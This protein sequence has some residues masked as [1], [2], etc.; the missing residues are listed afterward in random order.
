MT[1]VEE[2]GYWVCR[3]SL[4]GGI[5]TDTYVSVGERI[6]KRHLQSEWLSR[7]HMLIAA[8]W[9]KILYWHS[10]VTASAPETI[11]KAYDLM[12]DIQRP[13]TG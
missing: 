7:G 11:L 1:K 12:P 13:P 8:H 9:L 3:E 2:L 10:G 4:L 6:L 5:P